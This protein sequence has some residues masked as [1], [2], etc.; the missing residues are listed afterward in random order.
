VRHAQG[1]CHLCLCLSN[2]VIR[3][4]GVAGA[5]PRDSITTLTTLTN[6]LTDDSLGH[7]ITINNQSVCHRSL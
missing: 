7:V 6:V 2:V 3:A 4:G 5:H 1:R